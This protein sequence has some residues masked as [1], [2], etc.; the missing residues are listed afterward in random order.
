MLYCVNTIGEYQNF[1]N[2]KKILG[3][4]VDLDV[5]YAHV[6]ATVDLKLS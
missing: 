6:I 5:S 2:S 4:I 3:N 1:D